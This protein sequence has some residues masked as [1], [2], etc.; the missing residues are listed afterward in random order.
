MTEKQEKFAQRY[1]E[2]GNA[3]EAYRQAYN[4]ENMS[5]EA[6]AVEACRLLDRPNVTLRVNELREEHAQRH[7]VTVDSITEE[8]EEARKLAKDKE[9][10]APM[11]QASVAKA[12]LHGLSEDNVN[13]S[14]EIVTTINR[15]IHS[16]T[17]NG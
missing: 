14:G 9:Q 12:K 13:L 6:I 7:A 8:L 11:V 1:I 15:I 3:S 5:N 16:A 2:T 4:A 17:D 10:A